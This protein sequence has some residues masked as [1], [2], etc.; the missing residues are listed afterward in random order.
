MASR[1]KRKRTSTPAS[2]PAPVTTTDPPTPDINHLVEACMTALLPKIKD[3]ITSVI[4]NAQTSTTPPEQTVNSP[5]QP[6]ASSPSQPSALSIITSDYPASGTCTIP[7]IA[8]PVGLGVEPKI[9]SKILAN[10]YVKFSSLLPKSQELDEKFHTV[11][12]DGQLVFVKNNEG[13]K[14]KSIHKWMEAFH[15][16]V[17]IYCSIHPSEVADLM[18]YAQIVQGIAKSCGDDAA[19]DYDQKFR[20]WRETSPTSCPWNQKN[21]ELF[22]DAM[23]SGLEYKLK[24]KKQPFRL[25]SQ[26][27]KY[28]FTFNN[29]GSCARGNTCSYLHVCQYCAGKHSRLTCSKPKPGQ[30]H[31]PKIP[32]NTRRNQPTKSD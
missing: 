32:D 9:K 20:Q 24:P 4:H 21:T 26:K 27:Q 8:K 2:S 19:I 14:I 28:C 17:S 25:T 16:F 30:D 22:Q 5:S 23:V 6:S 7:G 11:E 18:T 29:K 12:K 13:P 10:E 31:R 1:S 3:T 15:V